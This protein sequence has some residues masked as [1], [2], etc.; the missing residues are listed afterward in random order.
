MII[1]E[2]EKNRIRG[3]H[4]NFSIIKEQNEPC[5]GLQCPECLKCATNALVGNNP[6]PYFGGPFDYREDV[7]E[8][9][10]AIL[11]VYLPTQ[12]I[13][14]ILDIIPVFKALAL[15][16]PKMA[17]DGPY[18]VKNMYESGCFDHCID[19]EALGL[20]PDSTDIDWADVLN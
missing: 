13:P 5:V 7:G 11:K 16:Y 18:I 20:T 1:S 6:I 8:I 19:M 17:T 15:K 9:I 2:Q 3:L 10:D 4:K 14:N 12:G